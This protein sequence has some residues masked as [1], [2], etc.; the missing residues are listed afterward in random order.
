M[1]ELVWS[2]ARCLV[3]PQACLLGIWRGHKKVRSVK[4]RVTFLG[5]RNGGGLVYFTVLL[6]EI[7]PAHPPF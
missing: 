4:G 3:G 6:T 5:K 2:M 1:R 7:P